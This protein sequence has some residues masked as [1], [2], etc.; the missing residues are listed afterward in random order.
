MRAAQRGQIDA[1][2]LFAGRDV[3]D[4]D[5]VAPS[6][7]GTGVIARERELA[8]IGDGQLVRVLPGGTRPSTLPFVGSTIAIAFSPLCRT[9]NAG[10]GVSWAGAC[11]PR[12]R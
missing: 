1:V 4:G 11:G 7:A 12:A 3:D 8:V 10:D 9:S 6:R 5:G 2:Q